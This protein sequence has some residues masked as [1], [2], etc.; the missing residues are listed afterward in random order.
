MT[1]QNSV[2]KLQ[3]STNVQNAAM[4]LGTADEEVPLFLQGSK[5]SSEQVIINDSGIPKWQEFSSGMK[6]T[7]LERGHVATPNQ[8]ANCAWTY[9]NVVGHTL[10]TNTSWKNTYS[11][12]QTRTAGGNPEMSFGQHGQPEGDL[13]PGGDVGTPWAKPDGWPQGFAYVTFEQYQHG[14]HWGGD[15]GA[16]G[17]GRV[18]CFFP[19]GHAG[20]VSGDDYPDARL[21]YQIKSD[22]DA[23]SWFNFWLNY[24]LWWVQEDPDG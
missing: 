17:L 16:L 7:V 23:N 8:A 4:Y 24:T 10:Y 3:P 6:T 2:L 15:R 20:G 11:D 19:R 9:R 22:G 1:H 18:I 5:G 14:Y 21:Y 13:G 12:W